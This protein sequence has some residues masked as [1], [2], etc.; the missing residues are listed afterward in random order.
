VSCSIKDIR[1]V[2]LDDEFRVSI[3]E[4]S[5]ISEKNERILVQC[6]KCEA[7]SRAMPDLPTED[8]TKTPSCFRRQPSCFLNK[9]W[10]ERSREVKEDKTLTNET[11]KVSIVM[12]NTGVMRSRACQLSI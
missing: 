1:Y 9:R 10:V 5:R 3:S 7:L 8:E 4:V 6:C 12:K 11:M 2:N